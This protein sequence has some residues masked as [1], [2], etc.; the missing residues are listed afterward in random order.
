[1]EHS[2]LVFLSVSEEI[3]SHLMNNLTTMFY[4]TEGLFLFFQLYFKRQRQL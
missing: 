2:D 3:S 4:N 1:M